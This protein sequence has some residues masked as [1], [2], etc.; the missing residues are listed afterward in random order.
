MQVSTSGYY[1]WK[2]TPQSPRSRQN[3]KII[4]QIIKAFKRSRATYGSYA[5]IKLFK[6][7]CSTQSMSG[8]EQCLIMQWKRAFLTL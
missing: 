7:N 6:A 2:N 8:K 4:L 3:D 5:Y 1:Y